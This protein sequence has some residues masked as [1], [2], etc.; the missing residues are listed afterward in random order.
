MLKGRC[1]LITGSTSGLGYAVAERLAADGCNIVLNGLGNI[2]EIETQRRALEVRFGVRALFHGANLANPREIADL[3]RH[4]LDAFG[5]VDVLVNNA[6][7]R[8]FAPIDALAV[9]RWDESL[10]VNLSSA[11]HT[12]RLALPR[13]RERNWGRIVNMASV[14]ALFGA[15]DRVDYVTTKTALLGMTRAVAMETVGYDITCNAVCPG[16]V[17]TPAIESRLQAFAAAE[18]LDREVATKRFLA[19]RQPT[20]RFVAAEN[21][22]A[23]VAFLCGPTGRDI[24]GAALPIDGAW[25]AS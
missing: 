22:A 12:I 23:L 25:S 17:H 2:E 14:F 20:R 18:G 7:V 5:A 6:V 13:M 9:E 16:S 10:A 8:N 19:D 4:A 3:V 21:V 1:A 11:F 15:A 24:T